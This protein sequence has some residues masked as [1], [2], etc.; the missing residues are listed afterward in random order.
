ML[1]NQKLNGALGLILF[2]IS[3]VSLPRR[4]QLLHYNQALTDILISIVPFSTESK[5]IA[6]ETFNF[7]Q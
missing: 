2:Q 7:N 5:L 4:I 3:S 6:T 1:L